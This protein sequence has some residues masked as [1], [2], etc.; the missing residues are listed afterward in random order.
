ME[1]QMKVLS[2]TE[3]VY[4]LYEY[5]GTYNSAWHVAIFDP[6]GEGAAYLSGMCN[7]KLKS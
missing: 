6:R 3:A 5:G 1:A 2:D 7:G 4:Y